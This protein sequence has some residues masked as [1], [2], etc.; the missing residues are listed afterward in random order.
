MNTPSSDKPLLAL[1]AATANL[2]P[3]S[4]PAWGKMRPQEMLEH[5]ITVVQGS[6]GAFVMPLVVAEQKAAAYKQKSL[7]SDAP[8]PKLVQ[9]PLY[10]NGLPS[11][12]YPSLADAVSALHHALENF[13]IHFNHSP[14]AAA[15]H[16]FFG[17]LNKAEWERF[18]TKH[19][20]H[21]FSQFGLL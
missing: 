7:L 6:Q 13:Y 19:F 18:H 21:H 20:T 15:V 9:S 14:D 2:M 5:L 1:A 11:L 4:S 10:Q 12:Q 8:L 16:P 17:S 3:E